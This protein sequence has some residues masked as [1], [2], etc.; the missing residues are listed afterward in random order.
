MAR[1]KSHLLKV[2][3]TV[4]L[5]IIGVTGF[6]TLVN[7]PPAIH[8]QEIPQRWG[9]NAYEP[10]D[11]IGT[12]G[13]RQPGGTRGNSTC[14]DTEN[15]L[16]ALVPVN[17]FGVTVAAYPTFSFYMPKIKANDSKRRVELT[18]MSNDDT[19]EIYKTSFETGGNS[20]II[21]I[22]LPAHAGL[23]PLEIGKTYH[24]AFSIVCNSQERSEDISVHG[25]IQRVAL[26]DSLSVKLNQASP[27]D[28]PGIYANAG[29]WFDTISSLAELRRSNPNDS[30]IA[31][32]WENLL[33]SVELNEIA[34]EAF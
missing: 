4:A 6:S 33:R 25:H 2:S 27:K 31:R 10:P 19:Q 23:P 34:K 1:S 32:Q 7:T 13:K 28:K 29:I 3:L 11:D 12:P 26:K 18:L 21:S 17:S 24:W 20:R 15:Q 16:R 5:Q 9:A 30:A 14:S 8:A 22:G